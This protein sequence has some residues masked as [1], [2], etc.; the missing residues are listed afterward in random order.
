MSTADLTTLARDI[1]RELGK[2][3]DE[4]W[5]AGPGWH[6]SQRKLHGPNGAEVLVATNEYQN[7][8]RLLI[9]GA[10]PSTNGRPGRESITVVLT[11]GP[12]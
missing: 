6:S 2:L 7:K 1:A 5:T 12:A 4:T 11:R 3:R 10:Y 8:G 9:H